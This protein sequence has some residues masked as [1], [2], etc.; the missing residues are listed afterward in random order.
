MNWMAKTV[1]AVAMMADTVP[2]HAAEWWWVA[3]DSHDN[4]ALFVDADTVRRD[5]AYATFDVQRVGR[6]GASS[7]IAKRVRCDA[8]TVAHDE[9]AMRRFACA[10]DDERTN[11]AALLGIATPDDA[12]RAI[13]AT[14]GSAQPR[15]SVI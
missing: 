2:A 9:A 1:I 4:A 10:T 3:G 11:F 15:L 5:A 12:A 6:D 8:V 7:V 14:R 13:F